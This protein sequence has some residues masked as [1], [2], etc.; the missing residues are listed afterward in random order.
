MQQKR[1]NI[2]Q[3]KVYLGENVKNARKARGLT[4]VQLAENLS[5]S[6]DFI[7]SIE[8]RGTQPRYEDLYEI[9]NY[10]RIPLDDLLFRCLST[11][12]LMKISLKNST[13]YIQNGD[14]PVVQKVSDSKDV[15]GNY[16]ST[17]NQSPEKMSKIL[18]ENNIL[19]TRVSF[20]EGQVQLLKELMGK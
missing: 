4:Q 7:Q 18:E 15:Y 17:E 1:E 11:D 16:I 20:L 10:F 5:F 19:K 13:V 6:R 14:N 8:I 2:S 9:A 3:K 12:Y